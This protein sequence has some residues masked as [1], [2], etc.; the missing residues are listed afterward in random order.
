[1]A[2]PDDDT[3]AIETPTE[4]ETRTETRALVLANPAN[5]LFH[6]DALAAVS[7]WAKSVWPTLGWRQPA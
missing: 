6:S 3:V 5:R 2:T 7:T 4:D 1:M